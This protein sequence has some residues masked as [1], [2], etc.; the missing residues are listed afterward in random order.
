MPATNLQDA[1][2][3][4]CGHVFCSECMEGYI[5]QKVSE[6]PG[7]LETM[8]AYYG[9]PYGVSIDIVEDCATKQSKE[10][11]EKFYIENFVETAPYLSFCKAP[12]CSYAFL[13]DEKFLSDKNNLAQ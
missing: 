4:Q 11:F 3:F 1:K 5:E 7:S 9:C 12:D 10:L 8:C 6:G 13:V 2:N